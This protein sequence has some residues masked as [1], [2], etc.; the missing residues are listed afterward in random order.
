MAEERVG[1]IVEAVDKASAIMKTI[2][3]TG[4]DSLAAVRTAGDKAGSAL[5]AVGVAAAIMNQSLEL[6]KKG[7]ELFRLAILDTLAAALNF[8]DAND[9]V[10]K[11]LGEFARNIELIRARIGDVLIPIVQGLADTFGPLI[12]RLNDWIDK[13]RILLASDLVGW[14]ETLGNVA[15]TVVAK[16]ILLVSRA[17]SGWVEVINLVKFAFEKQFEL[18]LRGMA[19]MLDSVALV[20]GVLND[21]MGEAI[22]DA[23]KAVRGL[24]EEFGQSAD[25]SLEKIAEQVQAQDDLEQSIER[26]ET[27]A[28]RVWGDAAVAMINRINESHKGLNRTLE[29]QAAIAERRETN[30]QA[31]FDREMA[32]INAEHA[33]SVRRNDAELAM[34]VARVQKEEE[35]NSQRINMAANYGAAMGTAFAQIALAQEQS[36]KEIIKNVLNQMQIAISAASV[37]AAVK[38]IAAHSGIPFVGLAIGVAAAAAAVTAIQTY[39]IAKFATGGAIEGGAGG[40]DKNIIAVTRKERV[41]SVQQNENFERLVSVLD[42]MSV[43]T[44]A[45][46]TTGGGGQPSLQFIVPP[47]TAHLKRTVRDLDKEQRRL[48]R[49]GMAGGR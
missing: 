6:A 1:L 7:W 13:N 46:A 38:A 30:A 25:S 40:I 17:W 28:K 49:R 44:P 18:M 42:R 20:A 14:M 41:L 9:P 11:Q 47:S 32:R 43:A 36:S 45:A 4:K 22:R 16:G 19:H 48:A 23:G 12:E 35:L 37:E 34:A 8:R 26:I 29:E 24:G 21:D 2:G 15:I 33:A 27:A 39:A 3:K 5:K 10:L 31:F